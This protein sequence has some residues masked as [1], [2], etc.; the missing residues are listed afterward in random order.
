[1]T[2]FEYTI[3]KQNQYKE[4]KRKT[5]KQFKGIAVRLLDNKKR[6]NEPFKAAKDRKHER[7]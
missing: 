5:K 4:I 7:P 1:M 2:V 6:A 3:D